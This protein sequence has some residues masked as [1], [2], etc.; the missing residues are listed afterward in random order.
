MAESL[1]HMEYVERIV[2]YVKTIPSNFVPPM[3][4][5]DLPQY[6]QRTPKIMN[7]YYPD[8]FYYDRSC[9]VIGEAKTSKDVDNQHTLLQLNS[10]IEEVRAYSCERHIVLCSCTLAFRQLKNMIVRKKW[11]EELNDITFHILDNHLLFAVL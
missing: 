7:G 10:Y 8:V 6:I 5:V 1:L 4:Q 2:S 9:I 11:K 3:L